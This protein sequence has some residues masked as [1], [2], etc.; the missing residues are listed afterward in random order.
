V[1]KFFERVVAAALVKRYASNDHFTVDGTLIQSWASLKSFRP[2]DAKA[3]GPPEGG[4]GNPAVNFRGEKRSNETHESTT[5]PQA[6]LARKGNHVGAYLC[7]SGHVLAENRHGLCLDIRVAPADGHAEREMAEAM[8]RR[9]RQRHR[10]S[11]QTLGADAGYEAGKFLATVEEELKIQPHVPIT[12]QRVTT[13]GPE[14]EAR[15]RML[16]RMR[17]RAYQLSQ[18]ARKKVEQVFGWLKQPGGLRKVRHV[19]RWKIQQVAYL[20]GAAYNLLRMANLE[21]QPAGA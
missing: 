21:R 11:P 8:L 5:D 16:R 13:P 17:T 4:S 10:R 12:S 14:G 15:R 7:H 3:P 18:R 1:Q 20:W 9:F 6:R 2:K 19:G